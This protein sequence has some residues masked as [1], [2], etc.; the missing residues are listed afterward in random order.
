MR[1]L[2]L[3]DF[4]NT[5]RPMLMLGQML[6]GQIARKEGLSF[7]AK[8]HATMRSDAQRLAVT[9][10]KMEMVV[11]SSAAGSL[12]LYLDQPTERKD[13]KVLFDLAAIRELSHQVTALI[14]CLNHEAPTKVAIILDHRSRELFESTALWGPKV[15]LDFTS[16]TDD[17]AE[18]AKCLALGRGTA[19]VFHFVRC[20]EG[21]IRA[22]H[23]SLGLP[24]PTTGAQRNWSN[25]LRA[26]TEEMDKRWPK[27]SRLSGD[28]VFFEK[29][30]AAL[31]AMNNPYR[32]ET[33][34]LAAKYTP[35]EAAHIQEL[36]GGLLRLV[37]ERMDENG[38]PLA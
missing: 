23:G 8:D 38:F 22:V 29:V 7:L 24:D 15:A 16:L 4:L 27:K 25:V 19:A 32:N 3:E 17:I 20:L 33:M 28:S 21:A 2:P 12:A 34:H 6:V 9:L 26:I 13:G 30:V 18:G 35:E 5:Y 10:H 36:V 11:T 14:S 37:A 31:T 1:E